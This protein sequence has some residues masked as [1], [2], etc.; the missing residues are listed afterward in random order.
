M[1]A[2]VTACIS[3]PLARALCASRAVSP[4]S[5]WPHEVG[6]VCV[7]TLGGGRTFPRPH[8]S[9][10]PGSKRS[11]VQTRSAMA[12]GNGARSQGSGLEARARP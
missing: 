9:G 1:R 5:P 11:D 3:W 7:P 6:V 10:S 8:S 12:A 4:L 2:T